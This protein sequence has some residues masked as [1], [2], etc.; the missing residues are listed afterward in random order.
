MFRILR[1]LRLL[2]I[3]GMIML[4][5][6][7]VLSDNAVLCLNVAKVMSCVIAI[8]HAVACFWYFFSQQDAMF[9]GYKNWILRY[10]I[11]T[12]DHAY[13]YFTSFHWAL[14]TLVSG[15]QDVHPG[16]VGERAFTICVLLFAFVARGCFIAT[17]TTSM[18]RIQNISSQKSMQLSL[19]RRYLRDRKVST[20]LALR[21]RRNALS[22]IAE[23]ERHTPEGEIR[24]LAFVSEPLRMDLHFEIHRRILSVHA[25][26]QSY[27]DIDHGA[28]RR[29]C[30][31]AVSTLTL[32]TGDVLFSE[33]EL[34]VLNR[35]F[36]ALSGNFQYTQSQGAICDAKSFVE[37]ELIVA[38]AETGKTKMFCEG[39]LWTH[40]THRG[41]M[42]A[43]ST[44]RLVGVDAAKFMDIVRTFQTSDFPAQYAA[45]FVKIF[46]RLDEESLTD[47]ED[48]EVFH[49]QQLADDVAASVFADDIATKT[50][51]DEK[52]LLWVRSATTAFNNFPGNGKLGRT[53]SFATLPDKQ[54]RKRYPGIGG[55][56]RRVM[57]LAA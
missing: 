38:D 40:W 16:N 1:A 27:C 10:H 17:I 37:K 19:L 39:A 20:K 43:K 53:K 8:T 30:H 5:S 52:K 47:L 42:Q 6:E 15:P 22:A 18:T 57:R 50:Q 29:V 7:R 51:Q 31:H 25:F 36:F 46:N 49:A 2:K 55:V 56:I 24:L 13:K 54:T 32:H 9:G 34:P 44:S 48:P 26:F 23:Q 28:M 21:V 33:G 3:P 45:E 35:M 11:D 41:D 14:A 12:D 4:T